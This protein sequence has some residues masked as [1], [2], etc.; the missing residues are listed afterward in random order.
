MFILFG[1]GTA[2]EEVL[3]PK[4]FLKFYLT[5]GFMGSIAHCLTST[6]LMHNPNLQALGASGAISGV[7][8]IFSLMFPNHLVFLLGFIPLPAI[9]ATVLFVGSDLW[10]LVAQTRGGQMPI[11]HGAHLGGALTGLIYYWFFMR[12]TKISHL[13]S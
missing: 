8:V 10:G 5:A 1:F 9:M 2:M 11:G 4:R 6:F 7:L 12:R 3:G 13:I